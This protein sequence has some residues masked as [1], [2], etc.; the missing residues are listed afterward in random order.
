MTNKTDANK[1]EIEVSRTAIQITY[2]FSYISCNVEN[3]N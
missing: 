2:P 3:I 1:I